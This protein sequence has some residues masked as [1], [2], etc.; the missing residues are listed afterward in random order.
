MSFVL[1]TDRTSV[2]MSRHQALYDRY[3]NLVRSPNKR[4]RYGHD[5][6]DSDADDQDTEYEESVADRYRDPSAFLRAFK[7]YDS[8]ADDDEA[9]FSEQESDEFEQKSED[10]GSDDDDDEVDRRQAAKAAKTLK[11]PT[12]GFDFSSLPSIL[13]NGL[14]YLPKMLYF[15]E[16]TVCPVKAQNTV[17]GESITVL[18]LL[19]NGGFNCIAIPFEAVEEVGYVS[20]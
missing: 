11:K 10:S 17:E 5:V 4:S 3:G 12:G 9:Q 16:G 7:G 15:P 19:P 20:I 2:N 18:I 13:N 8:D 14:K 1:I 6:S